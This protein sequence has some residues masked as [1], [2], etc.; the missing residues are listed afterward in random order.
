MGRRE[1]KINDALSY[2]QEKQDLNTIDYKLLQG[3]SSK[4]T[5]DTDFEY[6]D[7]K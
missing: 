1:M 7:S 2:Y 6:V 3:V 5:F 4:I